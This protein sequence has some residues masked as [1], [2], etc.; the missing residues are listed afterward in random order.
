MK[1]IINETL[2][3]NKETYSRLEIEVVTF[4]SSDVI[5]TSVYSNPDP[6]EYEMII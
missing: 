5:T 1:E 3:E 6:D 4:A 2:H